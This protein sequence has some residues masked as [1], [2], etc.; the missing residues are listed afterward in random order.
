MKKIYKF[1]YN[2]LTFF[3][4]IVGLVSIIGGL[5][6]I[7]TWRLG[8]TVGWLSQSP[9]PS[10]L[11]PGIILIIVIGSTHF[12]ASALLSRKEENAI[13]WTAIAGCTLLIWIFVEMHVVRQNSWIQTLYFIFGLTSVSLSVVLL[14][15]IIKLNKHH[16]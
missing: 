9:Y 12:I 1:T 8:I 10:Y 14:S 16:S 4:F 15:I 5:G 7:A 11:E 6:L 3:E 2:F 13:Q